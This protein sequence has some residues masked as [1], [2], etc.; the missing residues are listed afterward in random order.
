MDLVNHTE[1][2][3]PIV[4]TIETI[5]P[6]GYRGKGRKN[7]QYTYGSFS[8]DGDD[9]KY[10]F[11]KQKLLYNNQIMD[12]NDI[13][14]IDNNAANMADEAQKECVVCYTATKNTVVLPCRHMCLCIDCS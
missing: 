7:I 11:L 9:M 3:F 13:Y 5:Y 6:E 10:K 14:G 4:I 1:D 8:K 2:F 12:L